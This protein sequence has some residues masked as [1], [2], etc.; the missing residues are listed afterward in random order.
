MGKIASAPAVSISVVSH[1]QIALIA[2]LLK[3]VELNC[4]ETSIEL[5]LTLNIEEILPFMSDKFAFPIK[6]IRNANPMGFAANHNQAFTHATGQY[7]CVLNPD[8]GFDKDPFPPLLACL[9]NSSVGVAAPVV[10]GEGGEIEDSARHFP[11][12]LKIICKA[13]GKCKGSDYLI[14]A[15]TIY[16]DW[17]GGMFLLFSRAVFEKLSGFD[18]RYFLYYEDVDICA[19]LRLL[20]YE[21]ALCPQSSVVHHAQ[22]SSHRSLRYFRWHLTSM[23]RFFFM[24]VFWRVQCRKWL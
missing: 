7:F 12:P 17:A 20:G 5:I 16:P 19:R 22:R 10:L 18:Q 14:G 11:T 9:K 2:N 8:V 24:P 21:V 13:L 15:Q 6:V 3:D 4:L 23:M 1:G